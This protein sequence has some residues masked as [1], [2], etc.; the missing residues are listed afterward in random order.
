VDEGANKEPQ[1]EH[2]VTV[3]RAYEVKL[4]PYSL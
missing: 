3:G 2:I 1:E 4:F